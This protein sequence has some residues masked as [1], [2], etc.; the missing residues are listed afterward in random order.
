MKN[1]TADTFQ[2][3]VWLEPEDL[4]GELRCDRRLPT[5]LRIR[6]RDHHYRLEADGLWYRCSEI[7]RVE[8]DRD[9]G[10]QL[11]EELVFTNHSRVMFDP[12][13]IPPDQIREVAP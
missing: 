5:R 2:F 12:A 6:E 9:T 8:T 4:C 13:L 7:W 11:G 10:E 3:R 1:E